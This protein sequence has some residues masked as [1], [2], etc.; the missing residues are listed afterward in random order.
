M[1]FDGQH[2][3]AGQE[4]GGGDLDGPAVGWRNHIGYREGAIARSRRKVLSV[5]FDAVEIKRGAVG[6][7]RGKLQSRERRVSGEGEALAEIVGR[8]PQRQR[9]VGVDRQ[10]GAAEDGAEPV[11][12]GGSAGVDGAEL[13]RVR[14][15]HEAAIDGQGWI[16]R[17]ET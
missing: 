9:R 2:V 1:H 15:R 11:R 5:N 13:Q 8:R 7:H 6:H 16:K 14:A 3:Q 17:A 12:V 10:A 4:A